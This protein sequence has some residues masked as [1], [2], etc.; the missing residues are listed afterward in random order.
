ML[1]SKCIDEIQRHR[2]FRTRCTVQESLCDLIIDSES[3]ENIISKESC[4]E[5][6]VRGGKS[7]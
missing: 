7:P 2:L 6:I 5:A 3:Q 4:G 1:S